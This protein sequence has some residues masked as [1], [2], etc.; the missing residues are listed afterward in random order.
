[1]QIHADQAEIDLLLEAG[2]I[3][4]WSV[5]VTILGDLC[6]RR[7]DRLEGRVLTALTARMGISG[8]AVRVALHRLRRDGWIES[9]RQ[10]RASA[11]CLSERGWSEAQ[12]VRSRIYSRIVSEQGPL[13]LAIGSGSSVEFAENLPDDAVMLSSRAAV[14]SAPCGAFST[15]ILCLPFKPGGLPHWV[16][17]VLAPVGLRAEYEDLCQRMVQIGAGSTAREDVL[18]NAAL[19]LMV[20]HHWRRLRLR[21]GDLPDQLLGA[22]WAGA[23]AREAVM[24][25]LLAYPRPSL[26]SLVQ[27]CA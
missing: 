7:E 27:A 2:P 4:V 22:Q 20:L 12:A 21:H 18:G 15:D 17:E 24:A 26:K 10:G 16:C 8:Q 5:I 9:E 3:K 25:V 19:R 23:R 13:T 11:Y 6:Q 1:M 14:S